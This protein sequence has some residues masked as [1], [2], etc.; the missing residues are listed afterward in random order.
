MWSGRFREPLDAEF[1][2]WQRS[3]VFDWRLLP[4]EVAASKAHASALCAAGILTE[5]ETSGVADGAGRDCRGALIAGGARPWCATMR[6]PKIF[7][8]CGAEAVQ[9]AWPAGATSF[10]PDAAATSRLR[11][12]C[13]FMCAVR[14]SWSFDGMAAWA[15][16]LVEQAHA[17]A[18]GRDAELYA[19]AAG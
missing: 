19:P 15:S 12:T 2:Q 5:S 16:A 13:G 10:T 6:P 9:A 11:P 7:T 4:Q 18:R 1:E 3:I 14:L 8:F 17:A